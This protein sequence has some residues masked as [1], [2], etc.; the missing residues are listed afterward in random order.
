MTNLIHL[1]KVLLT[2]DDGLFQRVRCTFFGKAQDLKVLNTYG[3]SYNPPNNSFGV[4]VKP[5]GY[6][7]EVFVFVDRPDLRFTGLEEGELKMGNTFLQ[8]KTF[9]HFKADGT[10]HIKTNSTL[11]ITGNVEVTGTVEAADFIS[12]SVPS[13]DAHVHSGVESGASNTG[14]PQ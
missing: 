13:Y 2:K 1:V 6:G 7:K 3:I 4:A 10:I 8:D 12:P 11:N 14:G 9:V 5:N